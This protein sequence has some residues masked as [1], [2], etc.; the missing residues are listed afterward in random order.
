M[1]NWKIDPVHSEI[2]FKVKHLVIS[3]VT[4]HFNSFDA[5]IKAD[6]EDFTN[7]KVTFEA[8]VDTISTNNDGRDAHLR[9]ADFF[10]AENH[11]KMTFVSSAFRKVSEDNFEMTGDMTIRGI[12]KSITLNVVYNGMAKGMDGSEIAGFEIT[13]K[14]NR[15]DFGLH[16]NALTEAGGFAVSADI[17]IEIFAEMKKTIEV[18]RAA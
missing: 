18:N 3:T 17:K 11:P 14:L 1:T 6:T 8:D 10:D 2:K 13:G 4:G 7:A 9:S 16:W 15:F 5:A 12:S